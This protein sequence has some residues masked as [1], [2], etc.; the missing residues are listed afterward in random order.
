MIGSNNTTRASQTIRWKA[1]GMP[2]CA[3]RAGDART[4]SL[5]QGCT[6]VRDRGAECCCGKVMPRVCKIFGPNA[7]RSVA[8][9]FPFSI[10]ICFAIEAEI[11]GS[12]CSK[13]SLD[14]NI[15]FNVGSETENKLYCAKRC[16]FT[17]KCMNNDSNNLAKAMLREEV[18]KVQ[19]FKIMFFD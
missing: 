11:H 3:G 7:T 10:S 2:T 16:R 5:L 17:R 13:L 4:L 18:G 6:L 14:W 19:I 12:I 8:K 9:W 1:T 15:D